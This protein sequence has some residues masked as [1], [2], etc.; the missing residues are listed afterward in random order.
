MGDPSGTTSSVGRILLVDDNP[1]NLKV[2]HDTL[3]DRGH[4]LRVARSGEQALH[5]AAK[6]LPDLIL[7]DIMMPPG[8]DGYETI[9][10]L[11][12]DPVTKDMSVIFLSAVDETADKVKGLELG[13]VDF[14]SKPFKAEEVM[15]RVNTHLMLQRL[16]QELE[17][18]NRRMKR[19]LDAAARVQHAT[20]PARPPD[21]TRVRVGWRYRP[22]DELGGDSLG[23][24]CLD[25]HHLSFFV[26]DVSGHGVP[27]ALL[28][29]SLSRSLAPSADPSCLVRAFDGGVTS[30]AEVAARLNLLYRT[31][32]PTDRYF[33]IA[34]GVL[35][36]ETRRLRYT[37]AGHA[38]PILIRQGT[39]VAVVAR[40]SFPIGMF[41][42][43]AF[44]ECEVQ[45][46]PADRVYFVSDGCYEETND[47]D[48]PFDLARLAAAL[49][50]RASRS[51]G[52]SIDYAC[53]AL[54][55]WHASDRLSDDLSIVGVEL[56]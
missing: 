45:L 41:D 36:L 8:I 53:Q 32:G 6:S 1:T 26:I 25:G 4:E 5:V 27:S 40:P 42:D 44:A 50:E 2:L 33:T 51:L 46:A 13:A 10:R 11:K 3:K 49:A 19:D 9:R 12:Q 43:V 52:D 29:V 48:E 14:I 22:C 16:R 56:T 35:D 23:V 30:P 54:A 34:Y 20:L 37:T 39:P 47:A 18:A 24:H 15:A 31:S 21:D 17:A 7:L 55:T 28:A 38:G